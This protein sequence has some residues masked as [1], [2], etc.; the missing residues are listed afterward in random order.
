[1]NLWRWCGA[2]LI[3]A[4]CG[5]SVTTAGGDKDKLEWKAF[6]KEGASFYQEMTTK[7]DQTMKV[8]GMEVKQTQQQTFY[9]KWTTV[10]VE[11]DTWVVEQEITGV[12]M[13]IQIGGNQIDYDSEAKDQP[14]NPLTDFFKA[15][16]GSKFKLTINRG[17]M[18][19]DKIE[20]RDV[21]VKNLA[22]ANEQ[23]KPLL[24]AILS[25][26]ALKQMTDPTF[27]VIPEKGVIPASKKWDNGAAGATLNM[28]PIGKYVT[29]YQY[30]YKGQNKDKLDEIKVD[31]S[32]TYEAPKD[33]TGS[34]LPFKITKADLKSKK[35][36][37]TVLFDREKGRIKS[38][39]MELELDG[40]LTIEI[41]GMPTEVDLNQTQTST[42]TTTDDKLP[43]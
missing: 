2:L 12:K 3:V 39:T 42:L 31:T 37:G 32:L 21:F 15:L 22:K 28:G 26:E 43:K 24:E 19:V 30:E 9:I 4:V 33:T 8:Q 16:K 20:G 1:M 40:K 14:N 13:K 7:T 5:V 11:K 6:D 27:A 23:L 41:A 36:S 38:S 29:K 18:K 35:G 10:K 34:N 25:E 17:T